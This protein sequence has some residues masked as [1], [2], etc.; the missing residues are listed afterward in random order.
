[1]PVDLVVSIV[2]LAVQVNPL[3][4]TGLLAYFIL[5]PMIGM[6]MGK[7][8]VQ[9][10]KMMSIKDM[11]VQRAGEILNGI[12]VIKLFSLEKVQHARLQNAREKEITLIFQFCISMSVFGLVATAASPMMTS[13]AFSALIF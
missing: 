11:R 9:Q 7:V 13:I 2:Y 12:K 4:L 8:V 10:K 1:M 6:V 3:A 5:F